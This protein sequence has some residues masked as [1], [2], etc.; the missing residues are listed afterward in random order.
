MAHT[1]VNLVMAVIQN[2][3]L[4]SKNITRHTDSTVVPGFRWEQV[5]L[6][7]LS[8]SLKADEVLA[9]VTIKNKVAPHLGIEPQSPPM[10]HVRMFITILMRSHTIIFSGPIYLHHQHLCS[11][12]VLLVYLH[13]HGHLLHYSSNI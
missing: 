2:V 7:Q 3:V 8:P 4:C 9:Y 6:M 1:E 13:G 5:V 10:C 12:F 11:E